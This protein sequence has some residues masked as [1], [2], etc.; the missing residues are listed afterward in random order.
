MI[1][2]VYITGRVALDACVNPMTVKVDL[3][4]VLA[5]FYFCFIFS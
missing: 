5:Y 3:V 4:N 1:K 2:I